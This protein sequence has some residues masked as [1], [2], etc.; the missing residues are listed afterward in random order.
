M[1]LKLILRR[2]DPLKYRTFKTVMMMMILMLLMMMM[3]MILLDL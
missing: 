1:M 3:R 2:L